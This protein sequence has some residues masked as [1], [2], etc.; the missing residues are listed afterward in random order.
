MAKIRLA[1]V[2]K[3]KKMTKYKFAKLLG[4]ETSNVSKYFK[5]GYDPKLSTLSKW[6]DVI[7]VSVKDLVEDT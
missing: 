6:A 4:A 7:G 3:Q 5:P 2:L 1:E